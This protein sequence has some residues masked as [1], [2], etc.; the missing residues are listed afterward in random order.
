MRRALHLVGHLL[1]AARRDVRAAD[2]AVAVAGDGHVEQ[3]DGDLLLLAL[4]ELDADEGAL[5]V[6]HEAELARE[7]ALVDAHGL[8]HERGRVVRPHARP[9]RGRELR[10]VRARGVHAGLVRHARELARHLEL[11]VGEHHVAAALDK[12]ARVDRAEHEVVQEEHAA[13]DVLDGAEQVRVLA[14]QHLDHVARVERRARRV[15]GEAAA[16]AVLALA[17]RRD[18]ATQAGDGQRLD[19]ARLQQHLHV[20]HAERDDA[21]GLHL[22]RRLGQPGHLD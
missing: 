2:A 9:A 20:A 21:A 15:H 1:R 7:A 6:A 17:R 18:L 12:D 3:R 13:E 10:H 19:R 22:A 8:A 5:L 16:A 14:R 4:A 11:G